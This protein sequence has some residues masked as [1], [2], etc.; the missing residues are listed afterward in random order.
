MTGQLKEIAEM[1]N[2]G[3]T[4]EIKPL[5]NGLINETFVVATDDGQKYVLQKLH[6]I[7]KPE[8]IEDI[9]NITTCLAQ[10]G[11]L[12]PRVIKTKT[13]ELCVLIGDECWRMLTF[14]RGKCFQ[15]GINEDQAYSAAML[16]GKFHFFM[17]GFPYQFKHRLSGFRDTEKR[18]KN[19]RSVLEKFKD[20]EKYTIL[21]PL[22]KYII[23]Y[24]A[25]L[26]DSTAILPTR[27][28]HGD[29]KLNNVLFDESGEN[30]VSLLDLDTIGEHKV[31]FDFAD[32]TRTWCNKVGEDHLHFPYPMFDL[33]IFTAMLNGYLIFAKGFITKEE[34]MAIP[35]AIELIILALTARFICDAFEESY[36]RLESDKYPNLFEQNLVRTHSQILLLQ[37]VNRKRGALRKIIEKTL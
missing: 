35:E 23:E 18:I 11:F 2:I 4:I 31:V 26:K 1:F 17:N 36:F 29:L 22:A 19:L 25:F 14:L 28:I 6:R 32:A 16:V 37:D 8:V 7:F 27:I 21:E 20:T 9:D 13:G 24:H 15:F 12:T 30:A 33:A 34:L 5:G 3:Q 10:K